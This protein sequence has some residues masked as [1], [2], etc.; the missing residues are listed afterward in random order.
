MSGAGDTTGI[1]CTEFEVLGAELAIG[2]LSGDERG[3]AL[4]HLET[5]SRC[6][7]LV[8]ELAGVADDLLL[9]AP[10]MEPPIGFESRAAARIAAASAPAASTLTPIAPRVR[11]P[12]RRRAIAVAAAA[13]V[14]GALGAS[15]VAWATAG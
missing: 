7:Q 4:E 11:A 3:T 10:E 8:D 6:R 9:L 14:A 12:M 13:F 1:P 2:T 5:C 15:A